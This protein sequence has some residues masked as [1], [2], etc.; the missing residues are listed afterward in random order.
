M[1]D[2]RNTSNVAEKVAEVAKKLQKKSNNWPMVSFIH[3][4]SEI[5]TWMGHSF[6][7]KN[8]KSRATF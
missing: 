4:G 2:Y 6:K 5:A 1:V 7:N 3:N 8:T